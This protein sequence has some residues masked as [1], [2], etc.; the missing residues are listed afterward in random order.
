[1]KGIIQNTM[2]NAWKKTSNLNDKRLEKSIPTSSGQI[3]HIKHTSGSTI[4]DLS[5]QSAGTQWSAKRKSEITDDIGK[6][7]HEN[8]KDTYHP[9][10]FAESPLYP[11]QEQIQKQNDQDILQQE[12]DPFQKWAASSS[13]TIENRRRKSLQ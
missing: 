11:L 8:E 6:N 2:E 12:D 4:V 10:Q 1:M 9:Q 13:D 3:D 5:N 7:Q